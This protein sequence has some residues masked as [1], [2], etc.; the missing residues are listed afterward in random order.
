MTKKATAMHLEANFDID[1]VGST[2]EWSFKRYDC[3]GN[4]LTGKYAG[5]I[6]FTTGEEMRVRVRAGCRT[7]LTS[8]KVLDCTLISIPQIVEIAPKKKAKFAPPSLFVSTDVPPIK[9]TGASI[10]LNGDDFKRDDLIPPSPPGYSEIALLWDK[11]LTVGLTE[12]RWE[13]SFVLTV[14]V[15]E[16]GKPP[17]ERVFCFDPEGDVSNGLTP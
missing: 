2:L 11:H 6:F 17:T 1:Q 3:D 12:G 7:K 13:I 5:G 10:K 4:P 14:Q 15:T 16:E 9:V 8:F